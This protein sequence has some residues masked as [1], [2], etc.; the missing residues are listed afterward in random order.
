M[1]RSVGPDTATVRRLSA[2]LLRWV[3]LHAEFL[4][5]PSG[6]A[7]LPVTPRVKALLQLALLRRSWERA[8]PADPGLDEVTAVLG[9]V[10]RDPDHLGLLTL[11][12][13]YATGFQLMYGALAP[14]GAVHDSYREV[15]TGLTAGRALAPERRT[16]F[17]QLE[18]R[19]YADLLGL[20]HRFGD[21]PALYRASLLAEHGDGQPITDLEVCDVTHTVFHLTDFGGHAPDL[22]DGELAHAR[23]RVDRLTELAVRG[24]EWELGAKLLLA[25]HCLGLDPLHT[26]SGAAVLRMLIEV[27]APGGA[28]PGRSADRAAED[29]TTVEFFRKSYQATVVA[30]LTTVTLLNSRVG[31]PVLGGAR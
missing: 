25:Q 8:T 21:Y 27:Q 11:D 4:D 13:R 22:T 31:E 18:T 2:G 26:S 7:E 6:R 1:T 10:W 30:A 16:P 20:A 12:P 28:I 3:R 23:D 9:R 29:G 17:G 5:S 24:Q 14:A 15:L 19:Y